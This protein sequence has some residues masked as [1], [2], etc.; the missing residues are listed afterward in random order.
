M[1]RMLEEDIIKVIINMEITGRTP[2]DRQAKVAMK[3]RAKL[4]ENSMPM[5]F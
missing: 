2:T 1:L 5:Q 4:I 3:A